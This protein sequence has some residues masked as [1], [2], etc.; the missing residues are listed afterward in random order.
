MSWER[1]LQLAAVAN[2]CV[3]VSAILA[4]PE[5]ANRG[6][7][8]RS[9]WNNLEAPLHY[10]AMHGRTDI[11]LALHAAGVDVNSRMVNR[12]SGSDGVIPR[13]YSCTALHLAMYGVPQVATVKLLLELGADAKLQG[14]W[15]ELSGTPLDWAR[16]RQF[17]DVVAVLVQHSGEERRVGDREHLRNEHS[18]QETCW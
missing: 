2:L 9:V 1:E 17:V 11:I 5:V 8:G 3:K 4:R 14:T 7:L 10:A 12:L 6:N 16:K 15:Q 18:L 13:R